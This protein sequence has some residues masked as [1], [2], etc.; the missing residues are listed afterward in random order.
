MYQI[1][2]L[3]YLKTSLVGKQFGHTDIQPSRLSVSELF[4]ALTIWVSETE[5]L[6]GIHGRNKPVEEVVTGADDIIF[7]TSFYKTLAKLKKAKSEVGLLLVGFEAVNNIGADILKYT[8]S[9][10]KALGGDTGPMWDRLGD[11]INS[12][13]KNPSFDIQTLVTADVNLMDPAKNPKV[14]G[15]YIA[16]NV[17]T[18]LSTLETGLSVGGIARARGQDTSFRKDVAQLMSKIDWSKVNWSKSLPRTGN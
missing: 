5:R 8:D 14:K 16:K 4:Q 7:P 18:A 2:Y 12:I 15:E 9:S 3:E 6:K 10:G 11:E 1:I 13:I 17:N